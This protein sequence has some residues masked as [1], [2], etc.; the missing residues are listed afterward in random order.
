MSF[1]D[2]LRR[3]VAQRGTTPARLAGL[4]GI[5]RP[6]LVTTLSG[7]HDTRGSTLEAIAGALDAQWVLVPKEHLAAVRQV[8]EGRDTGPD[9]DAKGAVD[10][11]LEKS[12]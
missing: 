10:L 9:R 12:K 5:A 3:L 8:L 7:K 11:F 4:V 6:N 2:Q 1:I